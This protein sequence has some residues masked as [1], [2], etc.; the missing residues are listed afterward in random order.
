MPTGD[1]GEQLLDA[2]SKIPMWLDT[3]LLMQRSGE[4]Q[5]RKEREKGGCVKLSGI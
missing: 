3:S 5:K 2:C 4:E 1:A